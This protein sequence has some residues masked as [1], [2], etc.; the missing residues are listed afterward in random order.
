MGQANNIWIEVSCSFAVLAV[1]ALSYKFLN[2][3]GGRVWK[4]HAIYFASAIC[5]VVFLPQSIA[6]YIF[7]D[8]TVTLVGAVYP[9]YRATKAVCTPFEDD[10]KEWLQFWMLGGVLFMATT[11]VDDLIEEDSR[12]YDIWFGILLFSFFWLYFPLTCGAMLVYEHITQPF[13]GPCFQPVQRRMSDYI[14]YIYQTLAN[15][16]HLYFLWFFFMLL[17]AGSKR[18]VAIAT[19]TVYPFISSVAA[20]ATDEMEDDTYWLTYWSVY[21][22]LFLIMDLLETWL[23]QVP[24]FYSIVICSTIYLMLPMFRGAEKV[25]RRVLVP[26]AGLQEL[27]ILRDSILIKKQMMKDLDPERSKVISKSIAKFFDGEANTDPAALQK[28]LKQSWSALNISRSVTPSGFG[29]KST[30]YKE[31]TPLGHNLV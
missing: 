26:L 22:C 20:A 16:T 2:P 15:A 7:T 28:E 17:P 18:T 1:V 24:G 21:G 6:S 27:M 8:L 13:L 3:N 30:G 29:K 14:L 10:D 5:T 11:W 25:F 9:I 23:G 12:A 31:P 19:G 4:I